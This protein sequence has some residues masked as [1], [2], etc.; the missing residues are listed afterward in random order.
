M[1]T[2]EDKIKQEINDLVSSADM[3]NS[4]A[5]VPDVI[6]HGDGKSGLD[7]VKT[8][9]NVRLHSRNNGN[10]VLENQGEHSSNGSPMAR[11]IETSM[12]LDKGVGQSQ[13]VNSGQ[14]SARKNGNQQRLQASTKK[15]REISTH[16]LKIASGGNDQETFHKPVQ[17]QEHT[18]ELHIKGPNNGAKG[19]T[20]DE[21]YTSR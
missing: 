11:K 9:Q 4:M 10:V 20:D 1:A 6:N 17:L 12:I 19:E 5:S 13:D 8:P 7:A 3:L 21:N 16:L 14:N 15:R 18:L 2:E